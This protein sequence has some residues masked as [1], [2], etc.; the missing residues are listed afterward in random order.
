MKPEYFIIFIILFIYFKSNNLFTK[1]FNN[2]WFLKD[3]FAT[4]YFIPILLFLIF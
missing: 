2:V 1:F 4:N 3:I